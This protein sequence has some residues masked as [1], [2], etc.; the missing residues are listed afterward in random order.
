[1]SLLVALLS[2]LPVALFLMALCVTIHAIGLTAA[3]RWMQRRHARFEGSFWLATRMMIYIA[4]WTI[5]LH[6]FQIAVW[7]SFYVWK[8]AMP[9][10]AT[11]LYFSVVTYTTTGYG[12]LVLPRHWRLIGGVEALT[13]ILM[14]GLSTGYFF[15]AAHSMQGRDSA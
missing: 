13:G 6:L 11:A 8:Q 2:E 5:L 9:D 4:G 7:A 1:M 12:D 15:A 3:F 10:M 14:C